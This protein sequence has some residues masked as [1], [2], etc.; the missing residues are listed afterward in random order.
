[1][2]ETRTHHFDSKT[3]SQSMDWK[4]YGSPATCKFRQH[5]SAG[6]IMASVFWDAEGILMIDYLQHGETITSDYYANLIRNVREAI[7]E[8]RRGKLRLKVLFHQD[9]APVHKSG[10]AM[11]ALNKAG[12]EIVH[13]PPYSPDLAPSNFYL[14]PN[15]KGHLR[16]QKF[17][18]NN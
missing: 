15:L 17:E 13:H 18:S 8:K 4:Q 7:K 16:G 6:K 10:V 1:M 5:L 2:D 14:F 12:F 3:K 11:A 9:N